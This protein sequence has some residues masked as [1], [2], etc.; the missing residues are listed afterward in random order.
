MCYLGVSNQFTFG[1]Y[2]P[3]PYVKWKDWTC[4]SCLTSAGVSRMEVQTA[5][6]MLAMSMVTVLSFSWFVM[7]A[8]V[9]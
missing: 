3:D 2:V 7:G 8:G 6:F 5:G 4:S 9:V 1:M